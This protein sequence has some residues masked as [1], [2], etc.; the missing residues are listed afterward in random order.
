MNVFYFECTI[1]V[2]KQIIRIFNLP[3]LPVGQEF[4]ADN[5]AKYL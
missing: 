4:V 1:T 2:N 3:I 5:S